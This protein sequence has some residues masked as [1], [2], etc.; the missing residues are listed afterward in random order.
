MIPKVT[1]VVW[2]GF[3]PD[4]VS[5]ELT[6]TL[7]TLIDRGV[8]FAS[9]RCTYPPHTRVNCASLITSSW[10]ET[11]G[12][13]ANQLHLAQTG[14]TSPWSLAER[15][16]ILTLEDLAA[17]GLFG[18]PSLGETLGAS[19]LS[20]AVVS[21]ASSG[22][23]SIIGWGASVVVGD[24]V[25]YPK[26]VAVS[27][28]HRFGQSPGRHNPDTS[29]LNRYMNEVVLACILPDV[30]PDVLLVWLGEPDAAQHAHGVGSRESRKAI[31]V[32]DALLADLLRGLGDEANVIITSDHGHTQA[33]PA[34]HT[35]SSVVEEATGLMEGSD[36]LLVSDAIYLL[37]DNAE[38]AVAPAVAALLECPWVGHIFTTTPCR[39]ALPMS[40]VGLGGPWAPH[41]KFSG[42]WKDRAAPSGL[43]AVVRT[44]A[45]CSYRST[46]GTLGLTDMNNLLV[47]AGPA[48][49]ESARSDIPCGIVDIAPTVLSIAGAPIPKAWQGRRLSEALVEA[50]N[51]SGLDVEWETIGT[52]NEGSAQTVVKAWVGGT[53]YLWSGTPHH[54]TKQQEAPNAS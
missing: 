26:D 4:Y 17:D 3:R 44:G 38:D 29:R 12:L 36:F 9:S 27:V 48:F 45:E 43:P 18:V 10:P 23:T 19:G 28:E 16:T 14:S 8:S 21:A 24:G 31:A 53:P 50:K 35:T 20:L 41:I 13:V 42:V 25:G 54:V 22:S 33:E 30:Q 49:R 47:A 51:D 34:L 15:D 1:V 11:H 7:S 52:G 46:H 40:T 5:R 6:P 2:D 37:V 32:N 39:G